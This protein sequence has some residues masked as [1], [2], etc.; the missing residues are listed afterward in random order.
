MASRASERPS[1]HFAIQPIG[2]RGDLG[3]GALRCGVGLVL[4]LAPE[5]VF[6]E[7]ASHLKRIDAGSLPPGALVAGTMNR[8]MMGATERHRKLI[9]CLATKGAWLHEPQVMSVRRLAAADQA[10]L[11][12]YEPK[13]FLVAVAARHTYRQRTL[14]DSGG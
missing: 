3:L 12:D 2:I 7:P 14:V 4:A 9:A 6:P 8:T 13:M 11:A 10:R 5:R 1:W